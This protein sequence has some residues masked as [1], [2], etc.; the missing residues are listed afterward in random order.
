MLHDEN[1]EKN[2]AE[3]PVSAGPSQ[4][5]VFAALLKNSRKQ[6]FYARLAAIF[7]LILLAAVVY[8][9]FRLVPQ[10]L[11]TMENAN[12]VLL[13]AEKTLEEIDK[14]SASLT[15]TSDDL[16]K[17]VGTNADVLTQSV[18]KLSEVDFDGINDAVRDLQDAVGPLA[19][20]MNK[21]SSFSLFGR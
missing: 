7:T 3:Q 2:A 4:E 13:G 15:R 5:E 8:S 19:D 12:T 1:A 9:L 17:L 21:L 6:V 11:E 14:M 18:Q 16:S 10:A 20:A